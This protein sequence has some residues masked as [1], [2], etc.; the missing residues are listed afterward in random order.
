MDI[1]TN[2]LLGLSVAATPENLM[3]CVIGAFIGTLVGV[4]PGIGPLAAI[5][6]LLPLTFQI[7][8]VSSLIMLSGIYYGAT[9]AAATT[10]IMLNMPGEPSAVVIC[11]DGYPMARQGRAGVALAMA[12]I[13]SFVAGCIGI[14]IITFFSPILAGAALSFGSAEYAMVVILALG[15]AA[16][17]GNKSVVI[18]LGMSALGLLLSTVGTDVNSGV[19][20][21]NFGLPKL[22]EGINIVAIAVGLFAIAE[23][24]S[25]MGNNLTAKRIVGR[26]SGLVPRW[27]D[28]KQSF[29]SILRGT[30]LGSLIG[31]FPGA[32]PLLGSFASY[33]M[34][35]KVA[36][37]PSRFGKGAIE[38]VTGPE[39]AA[40]A[41]AMTNFI[42]MLTLGIPA[43]PAMA[44]M[45]SA[46]LIQG[47]TPGPQVIVKYPDLFWGVIASMWIGNLML[48]VLNLPLIGIWIKLLTMPYRWLYPGVLLFCCIG[49]YAESSS[50]FD[51]LLAAVVGVV[52]FVFRK[53]DCNPAPLVLSFVLG[54]MLEQNL[55]RA[56]QLARG[57]PTVFV[58]RPISL[59]LLILAIVLMVVLARSGFRKKTAAIQDD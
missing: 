13:S 15:I 1:L 2:L 35:K 34:E 30:G 50:S 8:P 36:K 26:V 16:T 25:E 29:P 49:V 23:T 20:R 14:V 47:I 57:D 37:D 7:P 3:Y 41:A 27:V 24:V 6:M 48:L 12:A 58:T 53:L 59:A 52:G 51:I 42:P 17:L 31:I 46:L 40:N 18:G 11:L 45:L 4:L 55:R 39:A 5:A 54:P 21:F 38:G 32:G 9:H 33:A 19:V 22:Y 56:L 28:I 44:L 10:S 43:G